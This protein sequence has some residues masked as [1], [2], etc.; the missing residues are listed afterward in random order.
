MVGSV[1]FSAKDVCLNC[2]LAVF[3]CHHL[4]LFFGLTLSTIPFD[5]APFLGAG[6]FVLF[7]VAIDIPFPT[8]SSL[9]GHFVDL[10]RLPGVTVN[11]DMPGPVS[12][13]REDKMLHLFMISPKF[14]NRQDRLK[15]GFDWLLRMSELDGVGLSFPPPLPSP[16]PPRAPFLT[17]PFVPSLREGNLTA[18]GTCHIISHACSGGTRMPF[19]HDATHD[20]TSVSGFASPME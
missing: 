17:P 15:V 7:D 12:L 20:A 16:V 6:F 4:P 13:D 10:L 18:G 1:V 2:T 5:V 19:C 11:W 8:R 9:G 3:V 14:L